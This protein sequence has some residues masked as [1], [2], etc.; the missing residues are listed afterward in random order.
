[1]ITSKNIITI[2]LHKQY[3]S[4]VSIWLSY[5]V[6]EFGSNLNWFKSL[7][8]GIVCF[9]KPIFYI[10][11]IKVITVIKYSNIISRLSLI[12]FSVHDLVFTYL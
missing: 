11:S 5:G 6:H 12:I 3:L 9:N 7:T 1:M 8:Y 4:Y 2:G 10:S